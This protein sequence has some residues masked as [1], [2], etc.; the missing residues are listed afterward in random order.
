MTVTTFITLGDPQLGTGDVS[1]LSTLNDY[2]NDISTKTYPDGMGLSTSIVN[3]PIGTPSGVFIAGDL[4][5][6]GGDRYGVEQ[7]DI[8]GKNPANYLGGNSLSN[9]R[10][11]YDPWHTAKG[12]T[13]LTGCGSIY[14]GL[15]NHDFPDHC[16]GAGWRFFDN[17]YSDKKDYARYQMWDFIAQM[18]TGF[19]CKNRGPRFPIPIEHFDTAKEGSYDW[20]KYSFNYFIDLGPVDVYQLHSY[21]GDADNGRETG[22]DWLK[23]NLALRGY[24][25]PVIIVQHFLF[26]DWYEIDPED[27]VTGIWNLA[28]RD[29]LMTVLLPYNVLAVS[30]GHVHN[31]P[32]PLPRG[33][34]WPIFQDVLPVDWAAR[35]KPLNEILPGAAFYKRFGLFRVEGALWGQPP[36]PTTLDILYA[37]GRKQPIDWTK[38]FTQTFDVPVALYV[39]DIQIVFMDKKDEN[40][41]LLPTPCTELSGQSCNINEGFGGSYVYI[42]PLLTTNPQE[43]IHSLTTWTSKDTFA[44]ENLSKGTNTN[45]R[46]VIPVRSP[47]PDPESKP[48]TGLFLLRSEK[49]ETI[50]DHPGFTGM[51]SNINEG[52]GKSFLYLIWRT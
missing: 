38:G 35:K 52:R 46:Y 2:L 22:I 40:T 43:G 15:G 50:Q 18:H 42:R 17:S 3:T 8:F 12:V 45:N 16:G 30:V 49:A 7:A 24:K 51:T 44:Y 34:V 19:T 31:P 11:L 21:G 48:M 9:V 28:Q 23:R 1:S 39:R 14:F 36:A 6:D 5:L 25:R 32:G 26:S 47:P 27:K 41:P 4:T 37:D 10:K 20:K 13:P 29:H 33:V